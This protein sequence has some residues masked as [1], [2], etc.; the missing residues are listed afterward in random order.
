MYVNYQEKNS[1]ETV[2]AFSV[3]SG[4]TM[5]ETI[6]GYGYFEKIELSK[7][8]KK[9]MLEN[10]AYKLGITED[11]TFTTGKG[12]DYEKITLN[13]D[14]KNAMTTIQLVSME[15]ETE[16][17]QYISM[18]IKTK[19]T[20]QDALSVYRK[21]KQS[22]EEI[23]VDGQVSLE[24]LAEQEGN[25]ITEGGENPLDDIFSEVKAKKVDSIEEN[26]IFTIYGYTRQEDTYLTLNKRKVNIQ[27]VMYYDEQE[28]KTYM[29][30]GVPMVNSSY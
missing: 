14:G 16:P 10:L 26:D 28:D 18:E 7:E 8:T 20:V 6:S 27:G 23:G 3:V 13:K 11:Y 22:Y 12:S 30:I 5:E 19:G 4:N 17:E 29:K 2:T 1:E 21:M 25:C 24:I 9:Q 15:T